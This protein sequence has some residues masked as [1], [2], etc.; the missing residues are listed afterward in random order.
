MSFKTIFQDSRIVALAANKNTGKTLAK[1]DDIVNDRNLI[2][3]EK[4]KQ[5]ETTILIMNRKIS[6]QR[7]IAEREKVKEF[8]DTE[9]FDETKDQQILI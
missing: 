1:I 5:I 3:N 7:R 2:L 6:K 9:F 8:Y 4:T